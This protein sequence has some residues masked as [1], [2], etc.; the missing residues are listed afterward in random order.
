M[1]ALKKFFARLPPSAGLFVALAIVLCVAI[2]CRYEIEAS[3]GETKVHLTP[4]R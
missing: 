1:S 3:S 4:P 2:L